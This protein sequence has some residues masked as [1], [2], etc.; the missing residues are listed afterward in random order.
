MQAFARARAAFE[1]G[2]DIC[3]FL[4]LPILVLAS[5][6]VAP[7]L[8]V[9]GL[10]AL[11]LVNDN[12]SA[13]WWRVRAHVPLLAALVL[14]GLISSLWAIEPRRS[15]LIALRLTGMFAAGLALV[16]AS[17]E[18]RAPQR[19]LHCLLAGFIL[20][21]PLA[22]VQFWSNGALTQA[23]RTRP[24]SEP[25][26][27]NVEDGFG[28]LLPPLFATLFLERRRLAAAVLAAPTIAVIF[29]LVGDAARIA[30]TL[31]IA[32]GVLLYFW[33][34]WLTRA[35]AVGSV[36]FIL[37]VPLALPPLAGIAPVRQDA[38]EVKFSAWHR[39]E[40]WSFVGGKIAQKPVLG[41][42]LDSSRAIPGGS[43]P[44]P[45]APSGQQWLPLHP[46]NAALQLWLELGGVGALLF[47]A[48]VARIWLAL[49]E[50]AWP[51]LYAAAAG[52]S[53]VIAL[54]VGFGSYG[55][56]QEWWIGTEFLTLFLILAMARLLDNAPGRDLSKP[57]PAPR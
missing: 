22:V 42:G 57:H 49:E 48:F 15:L 38:A 43:A 9:A 29:L 35:A 56:W 37:A 55:V 32:A 53:L 52:S 8:V 28:L 34:K 21:L 11:G 27:N 25:M 14:W 19:L 54:V 20:S 45:G 6:G 7:L 31:G 5:R 17:T 41:W 44:I 18:L 30:F 24:F 1:L 2:L 46:H 47:A 26:L 3:A 12:L 4:F 39:L 16:A 23:V 13:A 50:T 51:R 36:V 40:I 10:C 33:R